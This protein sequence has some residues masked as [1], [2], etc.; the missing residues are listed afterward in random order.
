MVLLS[1]SDSSRRSIQRVFED[2][3]E[4]ED[5]FEDED[6]V[7]AAMLRYEICG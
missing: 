6:D 2:E 1:I 7:I 4:D 3:D 5:E